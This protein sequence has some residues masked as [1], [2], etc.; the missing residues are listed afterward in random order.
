MKDKKADRKTFSFHSISSPCD[1][2]ARMKEEAV[3]SNLQMEQNDTGFQLQLDSSHG[4]RIVYKATVMADEDGGSHISGEIT[5]ISWIDKSDKKES[6]FEKF[7]RIL[8]YIAVIPFV[9]IFLLCYGVYVLF[10]RAVRGKSTEP[11][12]EEI[13]CD[14]MINKMA[15]RRNAPKGGG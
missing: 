4:G 11:T 13:L 9:L 5:A 14:F 10:V 8:F 3:H 12:E 15:T 1:F 7:F 6:V 2:I